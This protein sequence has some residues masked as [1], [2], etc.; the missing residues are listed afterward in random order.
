MSPLLS[1][2]ELRK[3]HIARFK[4]QQR[5]QE[6]RRFQH[7]NKDFELEKVWVAHVWAPENGRPEKGEW[8]FAGFRRKR[9]RRKPQTMGRFFA[10][11]RRQL[12][13]DK[14]APMMLMDLS[15]A[16][17]RF[18]SRDQQWR[19]RPPQFQ[20]RKPVMAQRTPEVDRTKRKTRAKVKAYK[21]SKRDTKFI[22]LGRMG[23]NKELPNGTTH[24]VWDRKPGH[25]YLG[26]LTADT[27]KDAKREAGRAFGVYR[28]ILV[29]A[30]NKLSKPLRSAM[31]RGRKVRA[32]ITRIMWPE[33]PPEFDAVF[34][35]YLR[36][37][38]ITGDENAFGQKMRD[39]WHA[40]GS[41]WL[42][43][44]WLRKQ[45]KALMPVKV[46]IVWR[47]RF[48][49]CAKCKG[50]GKQPSTIQH[51]SSVCVP[52]SSKENAACA[53]TAKDIARRNADKIRKRRVRRIE[54]KQKLERAKI[55]RRAAKKAARTKARQKIASAPVR[56]LR[57]IVS[58]VKSAIASARTTSGRRMQTGTSATKNTPSKRGGV[59]KTSASRKDSVRSSKTNRR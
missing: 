6:L 13:V 16:R 39:L 20:K 54:Q 53:R 47:D 37:Y 41:P 49:Q 28:E 2:D 26:P 52:I 50:I 40:Q 12:E 19:T 25:L 9:N 7:P 35:K 23:W 4:D 45:V 42:T 58:R 34:A 43:V 8:V 29:I 57:S 1:A 44:A 15:E 33:V 18:N 48:F 56:K 24:I 14:H 3:Q 5:E 55:R 36:K 17:Q 46:R 38:P 31:A 30:T 51:A 22:A 21:L 11:V 27:L 59:T 32:G 10:K